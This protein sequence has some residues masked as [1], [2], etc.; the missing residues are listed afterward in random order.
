MGF[1]IDRYLMKLEAKARLQATLPAE[2]LVKKIA[3]ASDNLWT[4]IE[5]LRKEDPRSLSPSQAYFYQETLAIVGDCYV[6]LAKA[7]KM[8]RN[9]NE[10]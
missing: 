2:K 10:T 9:T 6:A 7:K 5:T 3:V 1:R 4:V 8:I